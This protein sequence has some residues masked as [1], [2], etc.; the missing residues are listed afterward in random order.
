MHGCRCDREQQRLRGTRAAALT[1]GC[2]LPILVIGGCV[3]R[4]TAAIREM[5][6]I[7]YSLSRLP[8]LLKDALQEN[9]LVAC[10]LAAWVR[11][12][13]LCSV[14]AC[15]RFAG[16]WVGCLVVRASSPF[17]RLQCPCAGSWRPALSASK[18]KR[19]HVG[20][21]FVGVCFNVSVWCCL[22]ALFALHLCL[23]V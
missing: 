10:W 6:S 20:C 14:A 17:R 19:R 1:F 9:V 16:G 18:N 15:C 2:N 22:L 5:L 3:L 21:L 13:W 7:F 8:F 11:C 12:C 4:Q 23:I